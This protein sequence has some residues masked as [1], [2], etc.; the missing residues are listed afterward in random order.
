[1]EKVGCLKPMINRLEQFNLFHVH[2]MKN[3][4]KDFVPW[5]FPIFEN[6]KDP[7]WKAIK[8]RGNSASWHAQHAR[9]SFE[10]AGKRV[11]AGG[12]LGLS[13]RDSDLLIPS[14]A[15]TEEIYNQ[16]KPTLKTKG[17]SRIGGHAWYFATPEDKRLPCN[18]T[19]DKGEIRGLNQY[20]LVP[21]SY[22]PCTKEELAKK[23]QKEE[24][25]QEEMNKALADP[26]LGYYTIEEEMPATT[27]TFEELPKI[28]KDTLLE[29]KRIEAKQK[30]RPKQTYNPKQSKGRQSALF[31]L[32][33]TDLV[34]S[35]SCNE[36]FPHPLH[37]SDTGTNFCI[38]NN[39]GHCWRHLVSLNAIQFLAAKSGYMTCSQ[40]GTGHKQG[41][42]ASQV[43]GNNGAIFHAWLEAKKIG[44]IP[45][46]DPIPLKAMWFIVT[47]HK[48]CPPKLCGFGKLPTNVYNKALKIVETEY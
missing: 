17:R 48:L 34:T 33:I 8:A 13:G 7:D 2:L 42:G 36:R 32:Q 38:S 46:D 3:A 1:M 10:E 30:E 18:I 20:I 12:N 27:L 14:D 22:V 25:T 35:K 16:F 40:A 4:P 26:A 28:Y 5:Y 41:G 43:V 44:V 29:N 37:D 6:G 39:L 23:V 47:K 45:E 31:S 24:I 9:L 19:T 21:G 15:D 11:L